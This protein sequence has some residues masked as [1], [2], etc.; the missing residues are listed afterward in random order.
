[1]TANQ[2][3]FL[4]VFLAFGITVGILALDVVLWRSF[5]LDATFSRAF[6]WVYRRWPITS[7]VIFVWIGIL[8]GHLLPVQP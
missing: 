7:A 8:I 6:D 5:G 4:A 2:Q 3:A 1:M